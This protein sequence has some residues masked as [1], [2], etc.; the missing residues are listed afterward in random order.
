MGSYEHRFPEAEEKK[1]FSKSF[2]SN[3]NDWSIN[4]HDGAKCD[5]TDRKNRYRFELDTTTMAIKYIKKKRIIERSKLT[6][7]VDWNDTDMISSKK[8]RSRKIL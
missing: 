3:P 8:M 2:I 1:V 5:G 6:D 4:V 7:A